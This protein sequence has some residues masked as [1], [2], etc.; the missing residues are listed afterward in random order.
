MTA[1]QQDTSIRLSC[2]VECQKNQYSVDGTF[3]CSL[4]SPFDTHELDQIESEIE[5]IGIE[6]EIEK[7]GQEFKR[8]LTQQ[9]L[10]TADH[11]I[12]EV[13][14]TANP[15]FHKHGTRPFTIVARYG[16]VTFQRQGF[17]GHNDS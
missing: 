17:T 12:A 5:K 3:Q 13:A 11:R 7:I 10:E 6:S 16:D 2:K 15:G 4:F 14:Q 8:Q 9:I 1:P